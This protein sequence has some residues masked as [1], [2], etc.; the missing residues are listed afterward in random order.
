ML[1]SRC[2]ANRTFRRALAYAIDRQ[3]VLAQI[4]RGDTLRGCVLLNGPMPVGTAGQDP[5]SYA[6]DAEVK[7]WPCDPR[8][9]L[10]LA[11]G[12]RREVAAGGKDRRSARPLPPETGLRAPRACFSGR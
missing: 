5:L 12:G 8:L 9:A 7:P 1:A 4:V 2:R 10:V 6:S 3:A 11:E